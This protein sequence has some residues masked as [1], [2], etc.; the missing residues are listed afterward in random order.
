MT[1]KDYRGYKITGANPVAL[2]AYEFALAALYSWRGGVDLQLPRAI[3]MAPSF[4]MAHVLAAYMQLCS[5]DPRKVKVAAMIVKS[6]SGW[7]ANPRERLHLEAINAALADDYEGAKTIL[8]ELLRIYPRDVLALHVAHSFDYATGDSAQLSTRVREVLPAWST[9]M[10]G[11]HSVLA[12]HAFGLVERGEYAHASDVALHALDLNVRDAR[13]YHAIAHVHEMS[14]DGFFGLRWLRDRAE[15]WGDSTVVVTHLWWHLALLHLAEGDNETA[16][17]IYDER[18][19]IGNSSEIADMIDASAL[20]WR[21]DL[22]GMELGAR[23]RE[24]AASWSSHASDGFCTFNDVH[25]MLAF[26]GA[27]NWGYAEALERELSRRQDLP[28]RHGKTTRMVG[29][30]ACQALMAY[31]RGDY[32][33]TIELLSRLPVSLPHLGGSHAQRDVLY[34]TLIDAVMRVRRP[35]LREVA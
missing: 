35:V 11:Y 34:L 31:G 25:A 26:V 33:R 14:G 10:P 16:L 3:D 20:L 24:L 7:K 17:A 8:G 29:L 15:Y 1:I 6:A 30:P 21:L 22:L 19:R 9:G 13:A 23:W 28:T 32:A 5:R 4:T 27:E 2:E 12:M 18:V